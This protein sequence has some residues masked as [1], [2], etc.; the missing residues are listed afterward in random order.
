MRGPMWTKEISS[1]ATRFLNVSWKD[2]VIFRRFLPSY[3]PSSRQLSKLGDS[4]ECGMKYG[5]KK[6]RARRLYPR[7]PPRKL[8]LD[9]ASLSDHPHHPRQR[10]R[11]KY[12]LI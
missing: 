10:H 12:L 6:S 4:E 8:R 7:N 2:S 1:L 5:A 9:V 3:I 11:L